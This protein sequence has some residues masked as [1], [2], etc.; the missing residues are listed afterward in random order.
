MKDKEDAPAMRTLER[1]RRP[2][3]RTHQ[4]HAPLVCERVIKHDRAA[5]CFGV[6]EFV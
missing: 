1:Q 6:D 4:P 2:A 5:A 3:E